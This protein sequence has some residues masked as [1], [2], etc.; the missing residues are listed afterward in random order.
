MQLL[1]DCLRLSEQ[2]LS[3]LEDWEA[4]DDILNKRG[5]VIS[6]IQILDDMYPKDVIDAC[7]GE[8]KIEAARLISLILRL[9]RDT[10]NLLKKERD[11]IVASIKS[12]VKG[13]KVAGY[14][15][16]DL[17]KGHFVDYKK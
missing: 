1:E 7:S 11:R 3:R 6:D 12:N 8:Q 5:A 4:L 13:Q 9:D 17:E 2:L 14:G 16:P 15:S 10:E